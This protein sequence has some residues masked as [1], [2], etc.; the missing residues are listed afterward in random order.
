MN[1][2]VP[3]KLKEEGGWITKQ[4]LEDLHDQG[5]LDPALLVAQ[6][7]PD[8]TLLLKKAIK[9]AL[10]HRNAANRVDPTQNP[11]TGRVRDDRNA[12]PLSL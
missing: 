1:I 11:W 10:Q 4:L 7:N 12:L 9:L 5:I 2:G 8:R 6:V 3:D